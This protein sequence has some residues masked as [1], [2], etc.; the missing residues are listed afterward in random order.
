MHRRQQRSPRYVHALVTA[1]SSSFP[2]SSGNHQAESPRQQTPRVP[3]RPFVLL[4]PG[5]TSTSAD[6]ACSCCRPGMLFLI[7]VCASTAKTIVAVHHLLP[8]HTPSRSR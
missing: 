2:R 4:L 3:R 6:R 1:C 5:A 8:L 7:F